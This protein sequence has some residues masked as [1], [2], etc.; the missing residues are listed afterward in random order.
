[1]QEQN[2]IVS[3]FSIIY[4]VE[5]FING[6]LDNILEQESFEKIQFVFV[7]PNSPDNSD[8]ILL[9]Y[10]EKYSN[11]KYIKLDEDPGLYE[12]WNMAVKNSDADYVTNWNPDDRRTSDSIV[13]LY[14]HLSELPNIDMI[15]GV[16]FVTK[17]DNEKT[18]DCD[19]GI[20]FPVED[21]SIK[22]LFFH[23]SPHCMPLW[24]KSLHDKY[25]YFD[26]SFKSAGDGEMWLRAASRGSKFTLLKKIIGSYYESEN[27]VSRNKDKIAFLV[28]EV[29]EMRC[30]VL[31]QLMGLS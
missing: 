5:K 25:G 9:P 6:L 22:N 20:V 19:S 7:N 30:K 14:N 28:N 16:T 24:K 1:M 17:K 10:L 18:E 2:Y 4:N 21:F 13:S 27:S 15:Y 23:N 8:K 11:F 31:K 26:N 29:Y 3:S 12:C